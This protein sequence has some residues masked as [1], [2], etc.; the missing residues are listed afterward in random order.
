MMRDLNSFTWDEF[1]A[2]D[3]RTLTY[4]LPI[5]ALEQHGTHLALGADDFILRCVMQQLHGAEAVPD[6]MICLPALHYGNSHEHISFRGVISLSCDTIVRIVRDI[7]QCMKEHGIK[8]LAIINSH[9]GNTA[10]LEAYAQEWEH[11]FGIKV[12]TI[13]FWSPWFFCGA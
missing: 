11:E 8:R 12:F 13:S 5:G 10:L 3:P 4:V 6:R 9:G 7:L 1:A 2:L